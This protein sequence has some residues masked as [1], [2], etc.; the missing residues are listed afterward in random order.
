MKIE[1][2]IRQEAEEELKETAWI[3][4][5]PPIRDLRVFCAAPNEE[6][7]TEEFSSGIAGEK[8]QRQGSM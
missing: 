2:R 1:D 5:I 3:L 6:K 4:G 8:A 7:A